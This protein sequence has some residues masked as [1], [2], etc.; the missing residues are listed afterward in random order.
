MLAARWQ[1]RRYPLDEGRRIADF[2]VTEAMLRYFIQK[3]HQRR[4]LRAARIVS[5]PSG[6]TEVEKRAAR[7]GAPVAAREV[8]SSKS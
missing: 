5:V 1:H 6:I 4:T 7:L 2:E 8:Y 3:A